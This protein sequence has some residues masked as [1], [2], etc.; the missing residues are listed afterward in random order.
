MMFSMFPCWIQ[1][2]PNPFPSRVTP[3][4]PPMEVDGELEFVVEE[5]LDSRRRGR[6]LQYLV[7]CQNYPLSEAKPGSKRGVM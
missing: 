2:P 6:G 1:P 4:H 7:C 3:P 5:I